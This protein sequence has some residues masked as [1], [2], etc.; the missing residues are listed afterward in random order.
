[1]NSYSAAGSRLLRVVATNHGTVI[2]ER[3]GNGNFWRGL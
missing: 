2:I 1:M 3:G